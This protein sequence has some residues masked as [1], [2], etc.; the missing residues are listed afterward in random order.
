MNS[1]NTLLKFIK[2]IFSYKLVITFTI[3][4][5]NFYQVK[6]QEK[7][8]LQ[9]SNFGGTHA[10]YLN[11]ALIATPGNMIYFDFLTRGVNFQNNF[12]E[13]NA[14]IKLNKWANGTYPSQ[15]SGPNNRPAFE[16]SW[17][18]M[19]PLDG[20]DK[21]FNFHQDIRVMSFM[22]PVSRKTFFSYNMRQRT[23]IQFYGMDENI[24]RIARYGIDNRANNLFGSNPNQ[25][26]YGSPLST[27]NGF[28]AHMESW[29]EYGFSLASIMK[30][31]KTHQFSTGFT[32]K[33]LRGMGVGHLSSDNLSFSVDGPDSVTFN[34]GNFTYAH[35]SQNDLLNPLVYPIEWF[36]NR[37][38]GI[39]AGVDLGFTYLKKRTRSKFR[40]HEFWDLG[41]N[42]RK[43]YDWKVGASLMD[44][45]FINHGSR[46][47]SFTADFAS[48][49]SMGVRNTILNGF[50]NRF[51]DGFERVDNEF[52]NNIPGVQQSNGFTTYLPAAFAAQADLRLGNRFYLG[53]NYQ[54]SLK[55]NASRGLNANTFFSVIPR[56]ESYFAEVAFPITLSSKFND[57]AMLGF[58]TRLWVFHFGSDN[59]GGLFRVAGNANFTGAS[60]YG[61][62][63]VPVPYCRS[64]S[65]VEEKIDKT[66]VKDPEPEDEDE[67]L[68]EEEP[69]EEIIDEDDDEPK[70]PRDTVFIIEKDTFFKPNPEL[71]QKEQEC[72]EREK[73]LERRI[74]ELEKRPGGNP[75]NC[76]DCER[77]LREARTENDRIR[78]DLNVERERVRTLERENETLKDRIRNIEKERNTLITRLKNCEDNINKETPKL[79]EVERRLVEVEKEKI[80]CESKY[81]QIEKII[82]SYERRIDDL[83]KELQECR[84]KKV[85]ETS[86]EEVKRLTQKIT[87][88]EKK[89][90]ETENNKILCEKEVADLKTRVIVLESESNN[91]KKQITTLTNKINELEKEIITIRT[92]NTELEKEL[93]DSKNKEI[94]YTNRIKELETQIK[95]CE[96]QDKTKE[97]EELK[98]RIKTLETQTATIPGLQNEIQTLRTRNT[99]LEAEIKTTRDKEITANTR[100]KELEVL[101]KKC[102]ETN[103]EVEIAELR[104]NVKSLEA[105]F[106]ICEKDKSDLE[107]LLKQKEALIV[108]LRADSAKLEFELRNCREQVEQ[109]MAEKNAYIQMYNQAN[110]KLKDCEKKLKDCDSNPGS[111][112][113]GAE[114]NEELLDCKKQV[115]SLEEKIKT[116]ESQIEALKKT[117]L[118]LKSKATICEENLA[119]QNA[120]VKE[121]ETKVAQLEKALITNEIALEDSKNKQSEIQ[122]KLNA[123]EKEKASL[124]SRSSPGG[125]GQ[126]NQSDIDIEISDLQSK[127]SVCNNN[128]K[129]KEAEISKLKAELSD[130]KTQLANCS[131]YD[132]IKLLNVEL[133]KVNNEIKEANIKLQRDL[134]DCENK[135]GES[136]ESSSSTMQKQEVE[137]RTTGS[138]NRTGTGNQ[139]NNR[140]T[141]ST[142][143]RVQQNSNRSSASTN[144]REGANTGRNETG[145]AR[146]QRSRGDSENT[147][148]NER[149]NTSSRSSNGRATGERNQ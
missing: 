146:T 62:I 70:V 111:A 37:T 57:K 55:D 101:L 93:T 112:Q 133:Q 12:L 53:A 141:S 31:S 40:V 8:G 16:Q 56:F 97:V 94:T 30:E 17:I 76:T 46:V 44:L 117:E 6:S 144:S 99:Q 58:Y 98:A 135:Q 86:D 130:T 88:L 102:E 5:S 11:P 24:A 149:T 136:S 114:N 20:S 142:S 14:P 18:R 113:S 3:L 2:V 137:R 50:G 61:G 85:G 64:R 51:Q 26:Q 75:A 28:K 68:E 45:G 54:A 80:E 96:E 52:I 32:F 119:Q 15:F 60:I 72:R 71:E 104:K 145:T 67:F 33:F 103:N 65:W 138:A 21:F 123:C 109:C 122:I 95:K 38:T 81:D 128:V 148:S 63:V 124:N 35:S 110:N 34:S 73:E 69:E 120:K 108:R 134:N 74:E 127:L 47:N 139:G 1:N 78:R 116:L 49:Q 29:Q 143:S 105:A 59:L 7:L 23:G 19:L 125:I 82:K 25:L 92:R 90:K 41:C 126:A 140:N 43:Q 118:D 27:K 4:F 129:S 132:N 115:A 121:W 66:I 106:K 131:D 107:A 10:I 91:C 79:I 89:I 48:P 100:V 147:E 83:E 22:F 77:R 42:Y 36:D 84:D 9:N 87:D 39:G 13:Y